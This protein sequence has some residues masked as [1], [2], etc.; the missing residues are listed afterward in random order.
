MKVLLTGAAG[1]IGSHTAQRLLDSGHEVYFIDNLSTSDKRNLSK[2]NI[3]GDFMDIND[4]EKVQE[5]LH[6]H[7]FDAVMHFA[8]FISV[9]ESV[10]NP[11]KYFYNNTAKSISLIQSAVEAKVPCFVFSSTAAV[12]G[13]PKE[14]P[15]PEE[16]K[17]QPMNP[18][19]L[20]KSM[21]E[22]VL[23][24]ASKYSDMETIIFRYFNAAG[25]DTTHGL[26]ELHDPE[27][28]LIPLTLQHLLGKRDSI[29]IFGTDYPT[30][31]GTC[32]RDYIHVLD[33]ADAH[34]LGMEYALR[35]KKSNI[36]NLGNGQGFSVRE[37]IQTAEKVTG[38]KANVIE[39]PRREGDPPILVASSEK[40]KRELGW[41]PQRNSLEH[42]I[43]SQW[44]FMQKL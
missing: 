41:V 33:L 20:S 31:D 2:L 13:M 22:Q 7:R 16:A 3:S 30:P 40:A 29:S 27:T 25:A 44:D 34:I 23:L 19:G 21:V 14:I 17:V 18:Y 15:I 24:E 5:L 26:G 1:Y 38:K 4:V 10:Q 43:K 28:H 36:F 37:V 6:T 12:Y 8:A 35:E 11:M 9:G 39:A 32:I 42:I